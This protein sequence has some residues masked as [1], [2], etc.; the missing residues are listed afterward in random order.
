MLHGLQGK[1][2]G[3]RGQGRLGPRCCAKR[4]RRTYGSWPPRVL[5]RRHGPDEDLHRPYLLL[6]QARLFQP[7]RPLSPG[8]GQKAGLHPDRGQPRPGNQTDIFTRYGLA[9]DFYGMPDRHFVRGLNMDDPQKAEK[10]FGADGVDGEAGEK[11]GW[12]AES[13]QIDV[14][15]RISIRSTGNSEKSPWGL[16]TF[17]LIFLTTSMPSTTRPNTA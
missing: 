5:L 6:P 15:D 1:N 3:M 11:T 17:Q 13:T 10:K 2:R 7:P 14:L 8:S 16:T 4:S 9:F 12:V